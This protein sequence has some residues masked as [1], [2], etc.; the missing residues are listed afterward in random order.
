MAKD[1]YMYVQN[2][3]GSCF[4]ASHATRTPSYPRQERCHW[5]A[6]HQKATRP[7]HIVPALQRLRRSSQAQSRLPISFV[8]PLLLPSSDC[9]APIAPSLIRPLV[10]VLVKTS[11]KEAQTTGK[12]T[13][14][15]NNRSHHHS[16]SRLSP[17]AASLFIA[18]PSFPFRPLVGIAR[19]L[20]TFRPFL[21][22]TF[23]DL[24]LLVKSFRLLPPL[25]SA[26]LS[27]LRTHNTARINPQTARAEYALDFQGSCDPCLANLLFFKPVIDTISLPT[28]FANAGPLILESSTLFCWE[29]GAGSWFLPLLSSGSVVRVLGL[30]LAP[31]V[32]S[33]TVAF[34]VDGAVS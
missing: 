9:T 19:F 20:S 28:F 10:P 32:I 13:G 30:A 29:L 16:R 11:G 3:A 18:L 15:S 26:L 5:L 23:S 1:T 27:L 21:L 24:L 4:T 6:F 12:T 33:F 22:T 34:H 25:S 7:M 8:S 14:K 31:F 17:F 2:G